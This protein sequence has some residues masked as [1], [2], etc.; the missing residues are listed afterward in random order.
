MGPENGAV[1]NDFHLEWVL[2]ALGSKWA[3]KKPLYWM[4]D[5]DMNRASR[6]M[7]C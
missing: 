3:R 7:R 1:G 4:K 5:G 6:E 2:I